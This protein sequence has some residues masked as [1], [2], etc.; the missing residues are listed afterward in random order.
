VKAILLIACGIG[1]LG[2]VLLTVTGQMYEMGEGDVISV[3]PAT[4]WILLGSRILAG[5]ASGAS[6]MVCQVYIAQTLEKEQ[7]VTLQ[8]EIN[9]VFLVGMPVGIFFTYLANIINSDRDS[10]NIFLMSSAGLISIGLFLSAGAVIAFFFDEIPEG[11]RRV[12]LAKNKQAL[13]SF[14]S[15][16]SENHS[17]INISDIDYT[18]PNTPTRSAAV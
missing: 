11:Y 13:G 1:L 3:E 10:V 17:S 15:P 7:R 5:I 8:N 2:A 14:I 16:Q 12:N 9:Q 4:I 6:Q 18:T